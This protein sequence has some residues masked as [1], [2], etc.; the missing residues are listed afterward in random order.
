MWA[1]PQG[2]LR[3]DPERPEFL[4]LRRPR[5]G[6]RARSRDASWRRISRQIR[7]ICQALRAER[8]L[9]LQVVCCALPCPG[10]AQ[11]TC[12][13]MSLPVGYLDPLRMGLV[14]SAEQDA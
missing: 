10:A 7:I 14:N 2:C 4:D 1:R 8:G 3:S 12:D 11:N 13:I 6:A 9:S 5:S